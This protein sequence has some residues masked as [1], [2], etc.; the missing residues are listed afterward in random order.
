MQKKFAKNFF[1]GQSI[2]KYYQQINDELIVSNWLC[3][4][5][6]FFDRIIDIQIMSVNPSMISKQFT[7]FCSSPKQIGLYY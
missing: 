7:M 5:N 3:I 1:V 4:A 2:G 6:G